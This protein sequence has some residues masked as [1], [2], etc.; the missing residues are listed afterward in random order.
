MALW[1]FRLH[2]VTTPIP[3][4]TDWGEEL[5][6]DHPAPIQALEQRFLRPLDGF[7]RRYPKGR[8]QD[9]GRVERSHRTDDEEFYRPYILKAQNTAHLLRMANPGPDQIA[10]FPPILLDA[11]R[12]DFVLACDPEGGNDLLAHYSRRWGET[13][14]GGFVLP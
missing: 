10:W 11:I 5:G 9:N 4:Q 2:G 6:G 14:L 8:K 1:W 13:G 3:F 12:A 7:L